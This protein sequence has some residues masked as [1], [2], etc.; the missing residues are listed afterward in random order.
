MDWR[1][2]GSN[3]RPLVYKA[4][5]LTT[6]P[7]RLRDTFKARYENVGYAWCTSGARL[8]MSLKIV[9]RE[10]KRTFGIKKIL[11]MLKNFLEARRVQ[12]V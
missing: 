12:G 7:R 2:L 9:A 3:L 6:A 11:N 1:S 5:G 8:C 4:S 10:V